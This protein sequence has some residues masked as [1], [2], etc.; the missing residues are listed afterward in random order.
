MATITTV[1]PA[2]R[3]LGALTISD[4]VA[5]AALAAAA[6]LIRMPHFGDPAFT[7]DEQFYLLVGDRM[8][9][10]ALPYVDIW[11]RKPIGLFLI[12]A[13][14][15]LLGG[16]GFWQY[17]AVATLFAIGTAFLIYRIARIATGRGPALVSGLLYLL[18]IEL[19]EGGGGQSPVFYNLLVAGAALALIRSGNA[20]D[21][22]RFRRLSLLAMLL[23]G[24]AIQVKYSVL[25]EGLCFGL[26]LTAW[27]VARLGPRRGAAHVLL[28]ALVALGPTIAAFAFYAGIGQARAFWFANFASILMRAP[29]P[30]AALHFRVEMTVL[31][32]IPLGLCIAVGLGLL[33]RSRSAQADR[34]RLVMLACCAASIFGVFEI[35]TLYSHYIL[36][37]F[38]P[39]CA[40][41]AP[42]FS[43]RPTGPLLAL[44][45]AALPAHA[46]QWPDFATTQRHRTEIARLAALIPPDVDK[47]CLQMF[48]GPP[49]LDYLSHGCAMSRFVFPDHL[50]AALEAHAIGVDPSAELRHI[51]AQRPEAITIGETDVRIPNA[52]TFAIMRAA[53]ARDYRL[54][55]RAPFDGRLIDIYRYR[56][57][58]PGPS[59][60]IT[61]L[62]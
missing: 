18:W 16:A 46:M 51:L 60:R 59:S 13:G 26:L 30:A 52:A 28:L 32:L 55:G 4:P 37:A 61:S 2:R 49:V 35:G 43:R 57:D 1:T 48:D 12:Y 3:G 23:T 17:Q 5:L 58:A 50:S 14:T 34:W 40:A 47:G 41:A 24:L 62:R 21:E 39:F 6:L 9:H 11:D 31:R 29:T 53:L 54:A 7:I 42:A 45:A 19:A 22:G 27:S 8:L 44:L 38:V 10:G 36:P 56:G 20:D 25:A 33:W 15:R